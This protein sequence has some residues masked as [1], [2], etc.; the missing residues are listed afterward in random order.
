[1]Y[2]G[3]LAT[4]GPWEALVTFQQ[5]LILSDR[6]G[7]VDM[8]AEVISRISTVPLEII[9]KGIAA[10]ELPDPH[11]RNPNENGARIKRLSEHRDWGW[12]IVNHAHYR[13]IR[14]AEERR[15]YMRVKMRERRAQAQETPKA[16]P[17]ADSGEI[18]QLVPIV[19]GTDFEVRE[20]FVLEL[21]K[22]YPA[23]D[24]RQTLNE[25]RGYFIGKPQKRKTP[26]GIRG[27]ITSWMGREQDKH[28]RA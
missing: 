19:G 28:G 1:M 7:T 18:V 12:Q 10:L 22:L 11:S 4:V 2:H 26:R 24:V 25:I 9:S 14:S 15:D 21:E 3:S 23:V 8:T 6:L 13:A 5:L 20:S 16:K 17:A 27:C